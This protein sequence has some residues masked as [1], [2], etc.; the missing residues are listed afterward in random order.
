MSF[1]YFYAPTI[2]FSFIKFGVTLSFALIIFLL[3]RHLLFQIDAV[4]PFVPQLWSP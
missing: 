4:G 2:L 3:E 1:N